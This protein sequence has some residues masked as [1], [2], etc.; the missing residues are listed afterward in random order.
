MGIFP[1]F[2][3]VE[4]EIYILKFLLKIAKGNSFLIVL[5]DTFLAAKVVANS[6]RGILLRRIY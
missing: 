1:F 6:E 2:F 3:L 5:P 4:Q